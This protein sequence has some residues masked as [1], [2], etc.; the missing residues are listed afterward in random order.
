MSDFLVPPAQPVSITVISGRFS[1]MCHN[2]AY[3]A[4]IGSYA[5]AAWPSANRAQYYPIWL[6]WPYL[7]Q[8]AFWCNGTSTTGNVDMGVY[9]AT[10]VRLYSTGATAA[11]ASTSANQY[12]AVSWLLPPGLLYFALSCSSGSQTLFRS[13]ALTGAVVRR[14][15]GFEQASA[16]PLPTTATFAQ[17]T[18][19]YWPI[20]GVSRMS[21]TW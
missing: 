2:A 15:G 16:H 18:S 19:T 21:G 1:P 6:P 17:Y 8:R 7:V 13:T 11:S 3:A 5:S 4:A 9:D 10:G 20:F 12:V 14:W